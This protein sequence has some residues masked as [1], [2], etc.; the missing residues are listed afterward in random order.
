MVLKLKVC[1][2]S[3][4]AREYSSAGLDS[5]RRGSNSAWAVPTASVRFFEKV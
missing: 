2:W 1:V 4:S 3:K 5:S